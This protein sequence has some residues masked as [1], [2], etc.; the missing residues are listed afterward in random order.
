MALRR[1]RRRLREIAGAAILAAAACGGR[2]DPSSGA[3]HRLVRAANHRDAAAIVAALA[4]D[5][6]GSE[7]M[8]RDDLDAELRRLFAAYASV[9]VS[10][11][12]LA[13]EPFPDF[14]VVRFYAVFRGRARKI[15]GLEGI[16]PSSARY[17]FELRLAR[18]G[19]RRTVTQ[20]T[21]EEIGK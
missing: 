21:W 9:D 20:A 17:R 1:S 18:D 3:V 15:G 19:A 13:V 6:R 5:F 7:G 4:P 10:I 8:G 14:D 2:P 12:G 11:S 16:L